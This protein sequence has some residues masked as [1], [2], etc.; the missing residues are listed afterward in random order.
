MYKYLIGEKIYIQKPLVLGQILQL[1]GYLEGI[2]KLS[3]SP[4]EIIRSLGDKLPSALAIVLTEEG[5]SVRGKD[6]KSL[7]D[8]ISFSIDLET[9]FKVIEDF[10]GCNPI[11][12]NL[13]KLTA[14]MQKISEKAKV[15]SKNS[16]SSSQEETSPEEKISSGDTP[17][18]NVNPS[19]DI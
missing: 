9:I 1:T 4:L 15:G 7:A 5:G 18:E 10:F 14:A 16:S 17:Q 8:E 12:L 19:P 6:L 2:K 3:N 13:E 11:S